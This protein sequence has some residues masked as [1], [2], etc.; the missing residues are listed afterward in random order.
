MELLSLTLV[1]LSTAKP[2][3][4]YYKIIRTKPTKIAIEKTSHY[5]LV[6]TRKGLAP[7]LICT[8]PVQSP[9]SLE[10]TTL[11]PKAQ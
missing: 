3:V 2:L 10:E 9:G 7:F 4:L 5:Q 1:S 8:L 11:G 6:S